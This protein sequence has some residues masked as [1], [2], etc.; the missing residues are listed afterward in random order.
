M[1]GVASEHNK[2]LRLEC[3]SLL[4]KTLNNKSEYGSVFIVFEED[5]N[6]HCFIPKTMLKYVS[7]RILDW[8]PY[9]YKRLQYAAF[10]AK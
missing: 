2:Q 7:T 8:H 3:L 4:N 1:S 9:S 10:V 6:T 5:S